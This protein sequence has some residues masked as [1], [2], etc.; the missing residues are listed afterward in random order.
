MTQV[1]LF[2]F[3]VSSK[4]IGNYEHIVTHVFFLGDTSSGSCV[5]K[6]LCSNNRKKVGSEV[7]KH[8]CF[9]RI[10]SFS[11]SDILLNVAAEMI[12]SIG[13][14]FRRNLTD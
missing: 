3:F 8:T 10:S 1:S 6:L 14:D 5:D 2:F 13:W 11:V 12:I 7:E 9:L 4:I